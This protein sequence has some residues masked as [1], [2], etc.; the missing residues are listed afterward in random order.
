MLAVGRVVLLAG[1]GIG[2][3]PVAGRAPLA[4]ALGLEAEP[5]VVPPLGPE[6]VLFLPFCVAATICIPFWCGLGA[7]WS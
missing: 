1:V 7:R 3:V 2:L 4:A 6:G 5:V